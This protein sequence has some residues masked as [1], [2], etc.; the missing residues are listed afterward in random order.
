M[1]E[2]LRRTVRDLPICFEV[3]SFHVNIGRVIANEK[4]FLIYRMLLNGR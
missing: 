4:R 1:K 2:I 3:Y